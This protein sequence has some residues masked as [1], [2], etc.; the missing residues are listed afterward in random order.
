MEQSLDPE[1]SE[2]ELDRIGRQA[3]SAYNSG[4]TIHDVVRNLK[5]SRSTL[6]KA[7]DQLGVKPPN[8]GVKQ[9]GFVLTIPE[10]PKNTEDSRGNN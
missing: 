1:Y 8:A 9:P 10:R 4:A 2:E 3:V 7:W 5:I 6:M